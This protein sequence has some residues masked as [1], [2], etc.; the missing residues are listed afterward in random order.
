[1]QELNSSNGVVA[2]LLTGLRVDEYFARTDTATSTFLADA[3]GS[4]VGLVGS[5]GSVATNY[6][7]QPF[8]AA[9]TGG[10]A[11][12]NSYQF[13]GREN[14]GTGLYFHRARYYSPA[15]QRFVSQDPIG[16]AGGDPNLYGYVYDDPVNLIDPPGLWGIGVT[17]GGSAEGGA[18]AGTA[19]TSELGF[20][21]FVNGWHV[22]I[23]EFATAGGFSGVPGTEA[24]LPGGS[25][26][27]AAGGGAGAGLSFFLTNAN[28]A[29][30][31]SKQFRTGTLDA[32]IGPVQASVQ[33]SFGHNSAGQ[34]IW[35]GSFSPP[36]FGET[37]GLGAS[38][39]NTYTQVI[40]SWSIF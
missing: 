38:S 11:N 34:P 4:T 2:N 29:N 33:G 28:C 24:S 20:G 22:S 27:L 9:T 18:G 32:G 10:A 36:L 21:I 37:V 39:L 31:L 8:G 5:G 12:G 19:G 6:T 3:L 25:N 13:T 7:Y 35:Q 15:F 40:G 17:L 30:D 23:G 16:F 26:N 14:D 1:M